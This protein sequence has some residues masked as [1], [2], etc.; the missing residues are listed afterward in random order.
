M[1]C[2]RTYGSYDGLRPKTRPGKP[3]R[4]VD[5]AMTDTQDQRFHSR[6]RDVTSGVI[7]YLHGTAAVGREQSTIARLARDPR[8][9]SGG[10]ARWSSSSVSS[11]ARLWSASDFFRFRRGTD[12][13]TDHLRQRKIQSCN[14]R[15]EPPWLCCKGCHHGRTHTPQP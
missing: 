1:W 2:A 7:V 9:S 8:A 4:A 10:S 5:S 12:R 15:G 13:Y 14:M 6:K 11:S 3:G